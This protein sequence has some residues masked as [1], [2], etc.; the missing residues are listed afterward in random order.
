MI[1]KDLL[2]LKNNIV[3]EINGRKSRV[4]WRSSSAD[5]QP[6]SSHEFAALGEYRELVR[7]QS[8]SGVLF[9][10]SLLQLTYTF[11]RGDLFDHRLC[12][13]PCPFEIPL[14]ELKNE[15]LVDLI[16]LYQGAGLDSLRLRTPLRFDYSPDKASP[17]HPATHLHMIRPQ[18][19]WA[20]ASP[21]SV[22]RFIRFI[23]YHFYPDVWD[24]YEF[25]RELP[26]EH[27]NR[28]I[29]SAEEELVHVEWRVCLPSAEVMAPGD[30]GY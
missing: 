27:C 8:Y 3:Q 21:V 13:Y 10:G 12:Y 11:L 19:R 26:Q 24:D 6:V 14:H 29:T 20:V 22:G 16:D 7:T 23:I 2:L 30:M 1:D 18:F 17:G 9:D 25:F 5:E 28:S 4:T 15:A